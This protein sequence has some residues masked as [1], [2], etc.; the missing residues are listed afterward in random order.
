V[1]YTESLNKDVVKRHNAALELLSLVD[2]ALD[3]PTL[4]QISHLCVDVWT[5]LAEDNERINRLLGQAYAALTLAA[6]RPEADLDVLSAQRRELDEVSHSARGR[7]R[8]DRPLSRASISSMVED[9]AKRDPLWWNVGLSEAP[10]WLVQLELLPKRHAQGDGE[11]QLEVAYRAYW[12]GVSTV[13]MYRTCSGFR[14]GRNKFRLYVEV[15]RNVT[16]RRRQ[17]CHNCWMKYR[18][19]LIN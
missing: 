6:T 8:T 2:V 19:T 18:Q 16:V 5:E 17:I 10:A 9:F 14:Q 11:I 1:P 3:Y 7:F 4:V 15:Y 13:H 12:A